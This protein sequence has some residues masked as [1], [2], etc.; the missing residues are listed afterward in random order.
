MGSSM[1]A[2]GWYWITLNYFWGI[3]V[4]ANEYGFKD[5][6][7]KTRKRYYLGHEMCVPYTKR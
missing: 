3:T 5:L 7:F 4:I 2:G 1:S 6:E